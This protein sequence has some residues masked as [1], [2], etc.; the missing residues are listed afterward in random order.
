MFTKANNTW[1][2]DEDGSFK[3]LEKL[4]SFNFAK[5]NVQVFGAFCLFIIYLFIFHKFLVADC[6]SHPSHKTLGRAHHLGEVG[7][8]VCWTAWQRVRQSVCRQAA[9]GL[10]R[11]APCNN[12]KMYHVL[13]YWGPCNIWTLFCALTFMNEVLSELV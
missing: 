13:K 7:S 4:N 2:K 6:A 12:H 9:V 1:L 8:P 3:F 10:T 5:K 11:L